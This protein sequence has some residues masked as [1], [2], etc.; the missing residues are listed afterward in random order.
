[1]KRLIWLVL[2]PVLAMA[3]PARSPQTRGLEIYNQTCATGYCHG[4]KGTPGGAPRLAARG[5]DDAY[6]S[7]TVRTGIRGTAMPGFGATLDRADLIAVVAY[8][9][10]L[11]GV[12]PPPNPFA[13]R[14][15]TR[16]LP[17]DAQRG[18]QL[19]ADQVRGFERCSVCHQAD[20]I[21]IAVA[22]PLTAVPENVA[23]LRQVATPQIETATVDGDSFPALVLNKN[24]SQTKLYDLKTMPPVLRTFPKGIVT[25]KN[26]ST[27]QHERM[28]ASYDDKE[29][30]AILVF[31]RAVVK[32]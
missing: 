6:V 32:P 20:G 26:G 18:R 8:V 2:A 22:L 4:V 12:T 19:F 24:G 31:L 14:A 9:D 1:M 28:L 5:F 3:Q 21:G 13:A 30:E 23:A 16:R 10:S 29:L 25:F 7:Q 27:W 11:N 15:E 17:P